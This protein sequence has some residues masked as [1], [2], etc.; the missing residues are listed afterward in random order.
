[1]KQQRRLLASVLVGLILLLGCASPESRGPAISGSDAPQGRTTPKSLTIA[2]QN[3]PRALFTIMGGDVGGAPAAHVLLALH[4]TLAMYDD[5]GNPYPMLVTELPSQA[6]G[7]WLVRPDG[8]MQTT[9][10]LRPN[11]RWH[12]GTPLTAQDFAFAFQVT[13]DPEL[14]VASRSVA[15]L[16]SSIETSDDATIAIGWSRPYPFA[17]VIAEP[18]L[19]PLPAHLLKDTWQTNKERF[20]NLAYWNSEF[21]GVGP[22]RLA[23]WQLGSQLVLQAFDGFYGGRPKIDTLNFKFIPDEATA[24][25]N[26]MAGTVD[27][28]FRSLDFNKVIAVKEE[29]ERAGRKPLVLIQPTYWRIIEVQYRPELSKVPESADPRLRQGLLHAIDRQALVDAVYQ[30]QAPVAD[31]FVP[32]DDVKWDW[33]KD[34]IVKYPYDTRRA[35]QLLGEV[36]WRRGADGNV[37][38]GAGERVKVPL[39]TTQGGQWES[40]LSIVADQWRSLGLAVDEHVI[41]GAQSRDRELTS[42]YPGFSARPIPFAFAN[43]TEQFATSACPSDATRWAGNNRGCYQNPAADRAVDGLLRSIDP[44]EQRGLWRDLVRIQIQEV[45]VLSLYYYVQGTIFREGVTGIKGENR[46]TISAT[47][48][49]TEWDVR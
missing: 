37:V 24:Y 12:D 39:W 1:M 17:N 41:P 8:T 33:V 40:E 4:Q 30:G 46:P 35:E 5:R 2:L 23:S 34:A 28:E 16:I 47:W 14:P 11:V 31:T 7:S 29:W 10:S 6:N 19:G 43:I 26:L 36:G 38:N 32:T 22:Y 20:Q 3:E 27:G 9:Y 44:A 45:P 21:V 48:N 25:A 13:M 42:K 18:D 15:R 49:V